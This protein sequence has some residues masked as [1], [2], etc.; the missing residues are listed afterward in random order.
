[1][2]TH[3]QKRKEKSG[4]RH[5][6]KSNLNS[7]TKSESDAISERDLIHEYN[8]LEIEERKLIADRGLTNCL[9]LLG[10]SFDSSERIA[11]KLTEIDEHHDKEIIRQEAAYEAETGEWISFGPPVEL[12]SSILAVSAVQQHLEERGAVSIAL[13]RLKLALISTSWRTTRYANRTNLEPQSTGLAQDFGN[14]GN[15]RRGDAR[16]PTKR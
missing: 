9:E 14:K 2:K 3:P 5:R 11:Q 4:K 1:L 12:R 6:G 13:E 8:S 15:A 7:Q 16:V 10:D